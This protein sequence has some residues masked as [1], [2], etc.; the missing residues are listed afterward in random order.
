M[1]HAIVVSIALGLC[2]AG[3][4]AL[5]LAI[6]RHHRQVYGNDAPTRKRRLLRLAGGLLLLLAIAP[7]VLLWGPG[8]GSVAWIGMQTIGALLAASLL[9]YWPRQIAPLAAAAAALGIAALTGLAL[10]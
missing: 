1:S 9:A 2:F 8:A 10:T 3:M 7:C 6:D 5:S 4:A